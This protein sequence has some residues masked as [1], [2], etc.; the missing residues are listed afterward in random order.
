M[1]I[2]IVQTEG[3]ASGQMQEKIA[4]RR[5]VSKLR[6]EGGLQAFQELDAG[7]DRFELVCA[8]EDP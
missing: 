2:R 4:W 6:D 1:R 5:I 7:C 3:F 8:K